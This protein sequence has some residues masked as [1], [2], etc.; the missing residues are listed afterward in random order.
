MKYADLI[1]TIESPREILV[2][3]AWL[4]K[5]AQYCFYLVSVAEGVVFRA[6]K[7]RAGTG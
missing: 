6:A 4:G 3:A 5:M 1:G 2:S 7:A